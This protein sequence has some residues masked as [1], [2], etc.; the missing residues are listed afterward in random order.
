MVRDPMVL[1]LDARIMRVAFDASM[2]GVV[3][4]GHFNELRGELVVP[5]ADIERATIT[6][7]VAAAS[8]DT[9]LAIRDRH[10]RGAS[11]LD[12]AR[13]PTIAFES[14]RII[15]DNGDCLVTGVL[16]LRGQARDVVTRC[17]FQQLD[18]GGIA[19]RVALRGGLD[20]PSRAHGVGVA[21]GVDVMNPL[22]ALVGRRV[23]VHVRLVVPAIRLL[24]ALLPALGH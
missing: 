3:V 16:R 10:L 17:A 24:P 19:G 13:Y 20:V 7:E 14:R 11:F 4:R 5:D 9:G 18:G 22:F 12:V 23:Q 21:R 1:A 2:A 8:I 6:V 15:R